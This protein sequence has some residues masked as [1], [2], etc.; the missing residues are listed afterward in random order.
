[1][2]AQTK[3][4]QNEVCRHDKHKPICETKLHLQILKVISSKIKTSN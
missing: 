1:M 4:S 3:V 2:N